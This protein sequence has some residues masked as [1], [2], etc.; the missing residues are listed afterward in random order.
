MRSSIVLVFLIWF[1]SGNLFAQEINQ[2]DVNG[3]RQG[4]WIKKYPGTQQLRYE[5]YFKDNK[6]VGTFNF[7]CETCG[8]QPYCVKEFKNDAL[9]DVRYYSSS[10]DL[11]STGMMQGKQRINQWLTFHENSTNIMTREFYVAGKL[12]G[13]IT[14]YYL[15]GKIIETTHYLNGLK[16][17]LSFYYSPEGI[18]L[19]ELS[20]KNDLLHGPAVYYSTKGL[21]TM[22]GDYRNGVNYGVWNYYKEGRFL[23][24]ETFPRPEDKN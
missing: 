19:K 17:G 22:K 21:L 18:T 5:G 13:E 7:Y 3:L 1:F 14:T 24:D 20:Y 23:F 4:T 11:V 15:T 6:E 2:K 10:G 8:I 16:E 9:V 12:Q